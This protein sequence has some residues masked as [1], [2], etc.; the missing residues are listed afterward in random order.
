VLRVKLRLDGRKSHRL[1]MRD[2]LTC[3]AVVEK[4]A[5]HRTYTQFAAVRGTRMGLRPR[6]FPNGLGL[7][8]RTVEKLLGAEAPPR[9]RV[10]PDTSH[11]N[12]N[13]LP[14]I[15][16]WLGTHALDIG[17]ADAAVLTWPA[18]TRKKIP[19]DFREI[20][21]ARELTTH[22]VPHWRA[23]STRPTTSLKKDGRGGSGMPF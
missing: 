16:S 14:A 19:E 23:C 4:I 6:R 15:F 1:G 7:L 13:G 2:R 20:L 17:G 3:T 12:C 18:G 8:A 21:R 22:A 9:A 10:N 11:R 5:E